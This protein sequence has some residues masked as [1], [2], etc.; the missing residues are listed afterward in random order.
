MYGRKLNYKRVIWI[1]T[2][3]IEEW[4]AISFFLLSIFSSLFFPSKNYNS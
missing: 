2:K 4:Y 3:D 1:V